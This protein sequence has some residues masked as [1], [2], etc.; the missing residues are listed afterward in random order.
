MKYADLQGADLE[1]AN[2]SGADLY[3][4]DLQGA[5]LT[6]ADL[7]GTY[8]MGANFSGAQDSQAVLTSMYGSATGLP[9]GVVTIKGQPQFQP[10]C[11]ANPSYG[12]PPMR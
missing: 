8:V 9:P 6:G 7:R 2:L 4:A 5:N 3:G 11:L 12:D 10:S 1:D